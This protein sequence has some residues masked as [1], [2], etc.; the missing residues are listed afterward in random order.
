MTAGSVP[1]DRAKLMQHLEQ[2]APEAFARAQEAAAKRSP[3]K[4][5][6]RAR[7]AEVEAK[8]AEWCAQAEQRVKEKKEKEA[9]KKEELKSMLDRKFIE[10]AEES[11]EKYEKWL[12][13]KEEVC[14][15]VDNS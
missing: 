5:M 12:T 8:Y 6:E 7:R 14:S 4:E 3:T 11:D 2:T 13:M 1:R 15:F 10:L 9:R